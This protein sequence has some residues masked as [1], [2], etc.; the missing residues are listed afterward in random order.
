MQGFAIL[1]WASGLRVYGER[2]CMIKIQTPLTRRRTNYPELRR[3]L[4]CTVK[5]ISI[6]L[7]RSRSR[8]D[9]RLVVYAIAMGTHPLYLLVV[10]PRS[11]IF[12]VRLEYGLSMAVF[13]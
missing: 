2:T 10:C 5:N 9:V 13:T 6:K 4:A 11:S 1:I 3:L 8:F 7:F 12:P